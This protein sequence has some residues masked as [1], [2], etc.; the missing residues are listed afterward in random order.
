MTSDLAA[1]PA[2][3]AD[4]QSPVAPRRRWR[5]RGRQPEGDL[6]TAPYPPLIRYLLWHGG[7]EPYLPDRFSEG[8]GLNIGAI[9]KLHVEGV[10]L[11]VT[12]DCG[13]SSITEIAHAAK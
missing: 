5:L 6:A 2:P 8:Y 9:D 10:T 7:V 1:T 3:V 12:A 13:T 11:I 4:F